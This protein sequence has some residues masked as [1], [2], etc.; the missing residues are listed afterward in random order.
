[1]PTTSFAGDVNA[2]QQCKS[3][4]EKLQRASRQRRAGIERCVQTLSTQVM[5]KRQELGEQEGVDHR[6]EQGKVRFG[7][8]GGG[9]RHS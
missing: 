1:M 4:F 9:H 6:T 5:A 8:G 2:T 3:L 7:G